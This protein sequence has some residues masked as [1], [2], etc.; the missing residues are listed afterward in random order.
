MSK[1]A[2]SPTW[3]RRR[4]GMFVKRRRDGM[5]DGACG[6]LWL[7]EVAIQTL[8]AAIRWEVFFLLPE[9]MIL[10][11]HLAYIGDVFLLSNYV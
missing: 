8:T 6:S 9:R 3:R 11:K 5:G 10:W 4:Y 1:M 2:V 7:S